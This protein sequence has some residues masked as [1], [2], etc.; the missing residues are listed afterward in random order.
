MIR[1]AAESVLM[2]LKDLTVGY[3]GRKHQQTVIAEHLNMQIHAGELICLLGPNG[4]GKSTLLKTL[5]G[6]LPALQGDVQVLGRSLAQMSLQERARALAL[7]LTRFSRVH[8]MTGFESVALGRIPYMSWWGHL[9]AVDR[10]QIE[11]A[12]KISDTWNLRNRF[13]DAMSDGERQRLGIAR[14]VAQSAPILLLD[15]PTAFLDLPH[16]VSLF[17]FLQRLCRQEKRTVMMS[18]HDLDLSL[19]FA[20]RIVLLDSLGQVQFDAPEALA[21][22]G[23]I[24]KVFQTSDVQFDAWTG[25]FKV[26]DTKRAQVA[27]QGE[28][29]QAVWT[30]RAL[31][32]LGF[33]LV[34]EAE[35]TVDASEDHVW[36]ICSG[37]S[38]EVRVFSFLS[39]IQWMGKHRT[40]D[41]NCSDINTSR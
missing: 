35:I 8:G 17:A 11:E 7:V 22:S 34:S 1:N 9:Q 31:E 10:Q 21:W 3:H 2:E 15:E 12:M 25:Y 41:T 27:C 24:G 23:E 4:S 26:T 40:Y 32:R 14:A 18:S 6:F 5:A 30:R 20:D 29:L 38:A 16:R 39:L 36:V 28:S 19:R 33:E 37:K 13:V